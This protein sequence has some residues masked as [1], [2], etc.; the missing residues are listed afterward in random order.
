MTELPKNKTRPS[1]FFRIQ[2]NYGWIIID[3]RHISFFLLKQ[4][5]VGSPQGKTRL[6]LLNSNKLLEVHIYLRTELPTTLGTIILGVNK[7]VNEETKYNLCICQQNCRLRDKIQLI[8]P[9]ASAEG[10]CILSKMGYY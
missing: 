7:T 2:T 9:K 6:I 1:F 5:T 3:T 8:A 4:I 10:A